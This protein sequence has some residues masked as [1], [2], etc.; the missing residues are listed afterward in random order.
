[1]SLVHVGSLVVP[2]PAGV[3]TTSMESLAANM[4]KFGVEQFIFPFLA[5]AL[6]TLVGAIAAGWLAATRKLAM[7]MIIG[8][9]YLCGGIAAVVMLPSPL[10]FTIV[11]LGLAYLPMGY[12]GGRIGIALS[13]SK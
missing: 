3:D 11:D 1:M 6:G 13:R 5:H 8:V 7:A 2:A 9:V 12:L 10:W 4:P